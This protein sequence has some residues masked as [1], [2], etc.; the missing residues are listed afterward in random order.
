MHTPSNATKHFVETSFQM[1]IELFF[2]E[3]HLQAG[4]S[5]AFLLPYPGAAPFTSP[6]GVVDDYTC[7]D[8]NFMETFFW[9]VAFLS[10]RWNCV[11]GR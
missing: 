4:C 7:L 8:M 5:T 11:T 3:N 2:R 1:E 6:P 9:M 10:F